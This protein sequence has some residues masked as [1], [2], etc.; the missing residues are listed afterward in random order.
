M[1]TL[2]LSSVLTTMLCAPALAAPDAAPPRVP[3]VPAGYQLDFAVRP[4]G[5]ATR[6]YSVRVTDNACGQVRARFDDGLDEIKVCSDE[7]I[8]TKVKMRI[9]WT[10]ATKTK[11]LAQT[12]VVVVERG[13]KLTLDSGAAKL[14]V[15]VQ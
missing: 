14:D 8:G 1:K 7:A 11:D 6:T 10:L 4:E 5:K 12:S 2:A 13:A 3:T 9:E 15:A